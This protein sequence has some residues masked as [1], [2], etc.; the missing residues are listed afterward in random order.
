[1]SSCSAGVS[2][3]TS[4]SAALVSVQWLNL[5]AASCGCLAAG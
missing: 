3:R 1:V 4:Q 2:D 5:I